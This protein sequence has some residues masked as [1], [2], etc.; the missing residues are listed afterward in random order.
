MLKS[1]KGLIDYTVETRDGEMGK[2]Q[3]FF[4]DD[5]TRSVRYLVVETGGWLHSRR[6]LISAKA[7]DRPDASRKVIPVSLTRE[8]VRNSPDIDA[9]KPVSRQY[10]IAINEY[11]GWPHSWTSEPVFLAPPVPE[12]VVENITVDESEGDISLRSANEVLTY[13]VDGLDGEIGFASDLLVDSDWVIRQIRVTVGSW[14]H[15]KDVL[16]PASSIQSISWTEKKITVNLS[17]ESIEAFGEYAPA[18]FEQE[19][20]AVGDGGRLRKVGDAGERK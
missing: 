16:L 6:V 14:F 5:K 13:R 19:I 2:V 17:R 20:H 10:E 8:Q 11:Y 3:N 12:V 7:V 1:V 4:F 15:F 18:T 9:D